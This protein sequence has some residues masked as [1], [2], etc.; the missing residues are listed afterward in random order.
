[1]PTPRRIPWTLALPLA[2]LIG[3]AEAPP[4]SGGQSYPI[5]GTVVEVDAAN[6]KITLDHEEI[7]GFMPAMVMPFVVREK[8][9]ALLD[10]A[11]PGDEVTAVLV[12]PDSRYWLEQIVVVKEGVPDPDATPRPLL[13]GLHMG[14][15][16]PDVTLVNQAGDEVRLSDYR[17]RT[18]ALTFIFTRCP[19][20]DFCPLMMSNFAG[21]HAALLADEELREGT[22]LLTVSFDWEHDTPEVLRAYGEP[23]QKTDPPFSHWELASGTEEEIRRLAE[24]LALDFYE[25]EGS[26][27]HNLRTA[28]IDPEGRLQS[29]RRGNEWTSEELISDVR[30]AVAE[31]GD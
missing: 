18:V 19:L 31:S 8:D 1:M 11:S 5:K 14:E 9:A 7:P 17:G 10:M 2:L 29:L 4:E 15:T 20:P 16:M 30:A 27:A 24:A 22:H 23:F 6:R 26:F 3:C 28:V 25:E 21:L 12:V 13:H